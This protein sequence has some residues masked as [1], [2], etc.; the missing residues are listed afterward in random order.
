M[1]LQNG[2]GVLRSWA[3]LSGGEGVKEQMPAAKTAQG[4][5]LSPPRGLGRSG[6]ETQA[7]HLSPDLPGWGQ[8]ATWER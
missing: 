6:G 8:E 2:G 5:L 7:Q 3:A 4:A 1:L